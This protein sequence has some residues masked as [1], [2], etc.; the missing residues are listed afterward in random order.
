M[1]FTEMPPWSEQFDWLGY[2]SI[3]FVDGM[4]SILIF[5]FAQIILIIVALLYQFFNCCPCCSNWAKKTFE[6]R[7]VRNDSLNFIHGT[8]FEIM[9]CVS[10]SMKMLKYDKY[11]NT[12]DL[13]SVGL[14]FFFA[15]ILC[16]YV[17]FV[18]YFT[19][20]KTGMWKVRASGV[21]EK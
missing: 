15:A 11:L 12:P 4:G 1:G 20:F 14:Q 6:M 2:N 18:T 10:V 13:V 9:V 17:L 16:L 19:I 7:K 21:I 3:N 8:F 5:A